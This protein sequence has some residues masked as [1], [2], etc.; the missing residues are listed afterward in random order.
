MIEHFQT[1][2]GAAFSCTLFRENLHFA[3]AKKSQSEHMLFDV[4]FL[5]KV[6]RSGCAV[7]VLICNLQVLSQNDMQ[8]FLVK[9]LA[10]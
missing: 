8:I 2:L 7:T 1:S 3:Y 10:L 9:P 4:K 6:P 5:S